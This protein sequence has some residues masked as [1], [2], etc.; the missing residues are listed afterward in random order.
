MCVADGS[1]W[2]TSGFA[3]RSGSRRLRLG[4]MPRSDW[5]IPTSEMSV[6][7]FRFR[8]RFRGAIAI[9]AVVALAAAGQ[10]LGNGE[11]GTEANGS[12]RPQPGD[13][14]AADESVSG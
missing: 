5:P 10:R 9:A 2:E 7:C 12:G 1:A 3:S 8:F 13:S 6:L 11:Q 4:E 14:D